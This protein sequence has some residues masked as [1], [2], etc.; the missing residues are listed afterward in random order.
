M[1]H[2]KIQGDGSGAEELGIEV[3]FGQIGLDC[4]CERLGCGLPGGFNSRP[5]NGKGSGYGCINWGQQ[6]V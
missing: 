2:G 5:G 1:Y 4:P 6:W 3:G